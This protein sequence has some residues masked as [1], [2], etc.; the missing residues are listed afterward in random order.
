M[1]S[2]LIAKTSLLRRTSHTRIVLSSSGLVFVIAG[3]LMLSPLLLLP[4]EPDQTRYA[5]PYIVSGLALAVAGAL[6]WIVFRSEQRVISPNDGMIIV[7]LSWSIVCIVSAFP[8]MAATGL[9]FTQGVFESVSGWTTTG[10]SMIGDV[11]KVPRILLLWRS[12][13]QLAGG[14]GL[15]IV[16]LA[17]FSLPVGAGLYRAEGKGDQL[18]PQVVRSSKIVVLL[19]GGYAVF[20]IT[21][22]LIAGMSPF[23]AVNQTFAAISTGGFST[24]NRSIGY[25]NS[26]S[27]EGITIVLMIAGNLNFATAYLLVRG[28]V[29]AF[30]LNAEIRVIFFLL[31][32]AIP[33]VLLFVTESIY[34][35]FSKAVRVA[36]FSTVSA[37]T[38]TGFSTVSY[39][40][41]H[42]SGWLVLTVLMIVGGGACSTA[43]G[44]KQYRIYLLWRSMIWE[45]RKLALPQR[46]VHEHK[47]WS[48]EFPSFPQEAQFAQAGTFT[49]MYLLILFAGTTIMTLYGIPLK[50]ALFEY[51]STLGTVGLSVGVTAPTLPLPVLWV[52]IAGMLLGRLEF[53]V[54]FGAVAALIRRLTR[55]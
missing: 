24:H 17:A 20:G 35:T 4:F 53:F 22:Y 7:V 31:L 30:F 55:R 3:L 46:V 19:Y 15:A 52:Q 37:L 21:A 28:K 44:I 34:P 41:W 16:M 25:W 23:D 26:P 40:N 43:G 12:I 1:P 50:A 32:V 47:V 49:F 54:V 48:G 8:V 6:L 14:A 29:K 5:Q 33:V 13:M 36:V 27:I 10:L 42:S 39:D 18:V 51:A 2:S 11:S 45:I 38:T 9:G